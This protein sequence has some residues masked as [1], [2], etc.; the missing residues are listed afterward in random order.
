MPTA[1]KAETVENLRERMQAA[2]AIYVVDFQGI[3]VENLTKLRRQFR[4]IDSEFQVVK[5]TLTRIAACAIGKDELT[6]YLTGPTAIIVCNKEIIGP[7]KVLNDYVKQ[8][9]VKMK[10]KCGLVEGQL[11]S[12]QE[13]K[14][15]ANIPPRDQLLTLLLR[16]FQSPVSGF[17]MVLSGVLRNLVGVLD[18]IAKEKSN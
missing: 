18:S 15:V 13:V 16:A 11:I 8:K 10:I 6:Q 14:L 2:S 12:A 17:A 5:N 1:Q 7:A 9:A 3:N 4:E